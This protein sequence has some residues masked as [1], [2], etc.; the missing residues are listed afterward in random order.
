[1]VADADVARKLSYRSNRR[2]P[3]YGLGS[4]VS[5][6]RWC[7]A[8]LLEANGGLLAALVGLGGG[9]LSIGDGVWTGDRGALGLQWRVWSVVGCVG[10]VGNH[11][12]SPTPHHT[13]PHSCHGTTTLRRTHAGEG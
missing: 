11:P 3:L 4:S 1:M 12:S 5:M 13:I 7:E 9:V 10:L 2:T 6:R 8:G